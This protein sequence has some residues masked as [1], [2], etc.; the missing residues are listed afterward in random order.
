MTETRED[1][2]I[3]DVTERAARTAYRQVMIRRAVAMNAVRVAVLMGG[4]VAFSDGD[5]ERMSKIE[6]ALDEAAREDVT[7][8]ST[9]LNPSCVGS[10]LNSSPDDGWRPAAKRL[11]PRT[12]SARKG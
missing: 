5:A 12:N 1:D 3:E 2:R 8:L 10:K 4:R 11:R 9:V 7:L 6:A